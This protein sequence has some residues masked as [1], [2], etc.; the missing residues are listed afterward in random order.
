MGMKTFL[1]RFAAA[2]GAG[3]VK[4]LQEIEDDPL[5]PQNLPNA[6]LE[7]IDSTTV[8][9]ATHDMNALPYGG[10]EKLGLYD[11]D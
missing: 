5:S 6:S 10:A 11:D 8:S 4:T 7:L 2:L 9:Y 1:K 3:A